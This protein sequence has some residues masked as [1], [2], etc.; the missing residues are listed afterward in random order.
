L[1]SLKNAMMM[2]NIDPTSKPSNLREANVGQVARKP[3]DNHGNSTRSV[4]LLLRA[5]CRCQPDT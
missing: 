5:P 1:R 3:S 4:G 2:S